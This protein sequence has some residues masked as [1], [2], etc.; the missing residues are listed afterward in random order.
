MPMLKT[1]TAVVTDVANGT[2]EKLNVSPFMGGQGRNAIL[3][4]PTLPLTSTVLL[5]GHPATA[6]GAAPA[7]DSTGWATITTITSASARVQEIALPLWVR[8]R[9]SVL[10]ADGPDVLLHLEG[11]Q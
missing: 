3:N 4:V 8:Y 6:T 2:P 11:I 9:T 10:D 7:G 1:L 5:Q